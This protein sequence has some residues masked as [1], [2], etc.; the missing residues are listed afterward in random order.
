MLFFRALY[1]YAKVDYNAFSLNAFLTS[2]KT[3][4]FYLIKDIEE[5]GT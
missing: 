2:D 4:G 5:I 3:F 1:S